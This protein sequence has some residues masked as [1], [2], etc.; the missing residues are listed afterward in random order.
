MAVYDYVTKKRD[1]VKPLPEQH[2]GAINYVMRWMTLFV[3]RLKRYRP[4]RPDSPSGRD[5]DG[6]GPGSLRN[7]RGYIL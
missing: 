3:L 2:M 6:R 5:P 4:W 7:G 1:E